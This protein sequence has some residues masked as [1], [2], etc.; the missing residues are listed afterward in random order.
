M[1]NHEVESSNPHRV[2]GLTLRIGDIGVS[3]F[4]DDPELK[5]GLEG[6]AQR[7]LVNPCRADVT[8]G[9]VWADLRESATGDRIFD[10][11]SVWQ[12]YRD[13]TDHVFRFASPVFGVIPYKEARIN[14]D[15]TYGELS[16]NRSYFR[17]FPSVYPFEYPFDELLMIHLLAEGRGVEVHGFGVLDTDG[18]GY[19]FLGQSGAG[20]TTMARLWT[21]SGADGPGPAEVPQVLSDDRIILRFL[22]GRL[23]MY[24]TPWHGEAELA[25]AQRTVV[26]RIFFL[27]RGEKNEVLPLAGADA[28]SRLV[29]CSFVPFHSRSGL[30]FTLAFL[31][32]VTKAVPCVEFRVFPDQ[33]AVDFVRRGERSDD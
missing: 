25:S 10:S 4:S 33:R 31:Q 11:G 6:P 18:Q 9:A 26:S 2:G 24:G 30:N 20:K 22:D 5:L 17:D 15:F 29:S 28:V 14:S 8:M 21:G 1:G 32:Q 7:F 16:F 3:V 23:W 27:G 19:L 12:L 13:G